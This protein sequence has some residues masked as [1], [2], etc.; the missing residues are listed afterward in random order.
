MQIKLKDN[1]VNL[2]G[3]SVHMLKALV[4]ICRV[5]VEHGVSTVI[6]TSANDGK[7]M[8]NSKHF[9]GHAV[10]VRSRSLPDN[11]GMTDD[12]RDRLG[13]DYDVVLEI[14]HI[15]VEYDPPL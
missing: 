14:D 5:W 10:D 1:S 8:T 6:I 4:T 2:D 11:I 9:I 13:D 12:M 15:H 3:L 7:H